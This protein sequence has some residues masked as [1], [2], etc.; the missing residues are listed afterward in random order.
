MVGSS[1][2]GAT[3]REAVV[4]LRGVTKRF[5][6]V[7]ANDRVSIDFRPGEVHVL[8]G[9]NGAGKSTLVAMLA[10]LQRPDEGGIV[11]GGEPIDISSPRKALDLGIG[12]VFQHSM[13]VPSLSLVDN[14]IL[15]GPW[16]KRPDRAG[17]AERM[18]ARAESIGVRL[19]PFALAGSLSL[20]ERQQAEIVRALMRGNRCL[21]LDEATAML[22]PRDA[23]QL[24][25]LMCRLAAGGLAVVFITHKLDEAIA[26]GD[27]ISVLRRGRNVASLGP[28]DLKA[29]DVAAVTAGLVRTMFGADAADGTRG[30]E[31]R[32]RATP[33]GPVV[34]AAGDLAIDDDAVPVSGVGFTI[35]A[36]EILGIAGIDG[37][38][39]KQLAEA[40]AGQRPI[41]A[42]SLTLNGRPIDRAGVG[43][44]RALGLRYVTD[45]RLGEG[46][47]G[48]FS[49]ATNLVLKQIGE[50]PFWRKGVEQPAAIADH[51][52]R[53]VGAFDVRTPGVGTPV[54]RLSG[55]NIQKVLL[56]RELTGTAEAVVFAKPTYGLD[57]R[58]T[59]ATRGRIREAA[60][61]GCA[62]LLISTD[63]GE[64]LEL[65]DRIAVM[66]RGRIVGT[67]DNDADARRRIGELMSGTTQ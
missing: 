9:E 31:G 32:R 13:L 61:A 48:P 66:S 50:A 21:I 43:E 54:A 53:R 34:L 59:H 1:V 58:N 25:A 14:F 56:A 22:T 12:T 10:G 11:V 26:W 49:V 18:R 63:I 16:W 19:D 2:S 60:E 39:Q 6:G 33:A 40:L 3:A 37:N 4:S 15:G 30:P 36:G 44:R 23:E 57:V 38:G 51:A 47:V 8:L 41:R 67:V 17:A 28:E 45:D 35:R 65:A 55:G 29:G 5:P 62:V 7:V 42:G 24:G 46:T 27:R 20:G 64:L 52:R